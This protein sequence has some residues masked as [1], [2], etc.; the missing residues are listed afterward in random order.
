MGERVCIVDT[1]VVVVGESIGV[2]VVVMGD[3]HVGDHVA[4][5]CL[6]AMFSAAC[7]VR[8]T[9]VHVIP[10]FGERVCVVGT[11][12]AAV[13]ENIGVVVV[14][15]EAKGVMVVVVVPDAGGVMVVVADDG[16]GAGSVVVVVADADVMVVVVAG[17]TGS[18]LLI[19]SEYTIVRLL[20][21]LL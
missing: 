2:V 5:D 15:V 17:G 14:V 21:D 12:V 7:S 16:G 1:K 18:A 13:G 6:F 10:W 4:V 20:Q 8:G 11:K 9:S 19:L 3:G